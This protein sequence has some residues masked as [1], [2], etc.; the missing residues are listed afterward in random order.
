[1]SFLLNFAKNKLHVLCIQGGR[2]SL[3]GNE[4]LILSSL[5]LGAVAAKNLTCVRD[6]SGITQPY[7]WN[8]TVRKYNI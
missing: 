5:T 2:L 4:P 1:M 7:Y 3:L 8:F 6:W